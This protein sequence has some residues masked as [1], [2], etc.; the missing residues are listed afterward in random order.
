MK[1]AEQIKEWL[2]SHKWYRSYKRNITKENKNY[3]DFIEGRKD[4]GTISAAFR[5]SEHPYRKI[6]GVKFWS[7]IH[8]E[9]IKW[10]NS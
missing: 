7:E 10:F 1:T 9:F 5:W 8:G 4:I 6:N 3:K 2:K